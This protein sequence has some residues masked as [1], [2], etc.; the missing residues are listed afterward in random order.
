MRNRAMRELNH[1]H[2]FS[3]PLEPE[4]GLDLDSLTPGLGQVARGLQADDA[5]VARVIALGALYLAVDGPS[6]LHGD[7]Y[8]GSFLGTEEGVKVIDPE[9]AFP[10]PP[11]FDLGVL[12]A[13]LILAGEHS[14]SLDRIAAHYAR[15]LDRRLLAEFAGVE[16]MRRL[17]GVAQ[18]PLAA[19]LEQKREW[20]ELSRSWLLQP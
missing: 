20:L 18:L 8:P 11:E 2:I 9:F 14:S 15:P 4:N 17:L 7:F 1:E 16:L 5:Y 12:S 19:E 10:G 6:L 13:H 3:L